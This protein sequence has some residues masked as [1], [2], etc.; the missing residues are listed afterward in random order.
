MPG[1]RQLG[2]HSPIG[3]VTEPRALCAIGKSRAGFAN[4]SQLKLL[5]PN[6]FL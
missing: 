6:F 1:K 3:K 4:R 2:M 5:F